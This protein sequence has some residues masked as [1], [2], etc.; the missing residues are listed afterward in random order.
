MSTNEP[1]ERA[2]PRSNPPDGEII[3]SPSPVA[4]PV[5][6]GLADEP[7]RDPHGEPD[8]GNEHDEW[9]KLGDPELEWHSSMVHVAAALR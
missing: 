6:D 7:V 8:D 5:G 1:T 9:A 2:V 4:D 3:R